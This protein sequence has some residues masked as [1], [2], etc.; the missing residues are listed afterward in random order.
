[1]VF[2]R[3]GDEGGD[4]IIKRVVGLPGDIIKVVDRHVTVNGTVLPT[5]YLPA[6]RINDS[7]DHEGK[8]SEGPFFTAATEAG[9]FRSH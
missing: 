8:T 4:A 9:R 6:Y 5:D 1:M 7:G 2:D 3:P